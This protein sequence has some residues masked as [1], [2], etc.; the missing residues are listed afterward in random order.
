MASLVTTVVVT[1]NS[2]TVIGQCLDGCEAAY[3]AGLHEVVVVDNASRDG[4]PELVRSKYP[5]VKV[6]ESGAN[7]GFGRGCNLGLRD[8]Q[9]RYGLLLNPDASLPE[10]ALRRLVEFLEAHP[11]A[12]AAAPA[13]WVYGDSALQTAGGLPT[14]AGIIKIAAGLADRQRGVREIRPGD[15]PLKTEWLGG[16]IMLLRMDYFRALGGFDPNFFLYFEETDLCRRA[17][18]AGYELWAVG[19]A[20]ARHIGG[21]AAKASGAPLVYGASLADPYFRSRF[22]YLAKHHGKI[23]AVLTEVAEFLILGGK[24]I[25][26]KILGREPHRAFTERMGGPF[27]RMPVF[28]DQKSR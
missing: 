14:P 26:K 21:T 25:A 5:W 19:D 9:T 6:I 28:P 3:A 16:G 11:R 15:A 17:V 23:Q 10:D 24:A 27:M 1:Y 20:V 8:A 2:S 12:A 22:Y 18:D 13:T 7:M 4:T